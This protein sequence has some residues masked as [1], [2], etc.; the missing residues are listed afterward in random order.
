MEHI[1]IDEAKKIVLQFELETNTFEPN[2]VVTVKASIYNKSKYV[3]DSFAEMPLYVSYHWFDLGG[4]TIVH[5]GIRNP[6]PLTQPG[7]KSDMQFTIQIPTKKGHYILCVTF[8][9]EG[10]QW[11]NSQEINNKHEIQINVD[12]KPWWDENESDDI[13]FGNV[14]Y[15]NK[16]KFK[17]TF[18]YNEM[19][20]PLFLHIETVNI[21]NLR[22][23]IC[24]C[25]KMTRKQ[26]TMSMDVFEK[27]INDYISLGGGDVIMTPQ[28]GDVF[29]DK[30]LIERIQFLKSQQ[31]INNIGFVTNAVMAYQY[32]D[33]ELDYIVNSCLRI[34][35]SIYGMDED[36]YSTMTRRKGIYNQM[37][38]SIQRIMKVK[39]D[40][41]IVFGFRN[42]HKRTN[43]EIE[44]W[45]MDNFGEIVP[46]EVLTDYCNWGGAMDT[47]KQLPYDATWCPTV[48]RNPIPCMYPIIHTKVL[49]NGDVNFCSCIDYD[50]SPE[51][52][53]GNVM[54]SDLGT[55]YNG[56]R[57]KEIWRNGYSQCGVCTFYK[58][59]K[60]FD[61]LSIYFDDPMRYLGV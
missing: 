56:D 13:V 2:E 17:K 42:L 48:Y 19:C 60:E 47:N 34:K 22:C 20:R 54:K 41:I 31:A 51:N 23:L 24:P 7:M 59:I 35:I 3:I 40:T 58:S 11:F 52:T 50:N 61:E 44:N 14:S 32:N 45:M 53:I 18:Y 4:E 55:I 9:Q 29:L 38:Q 15:M 10:V 26:E 36:E 21:C 1:S 37:V 27:A 46:Y 6:I 12:D 43:H 5:D 16:N 33:E 49:V 30:Y 8:V 25:E 39:K 57:A 28:I